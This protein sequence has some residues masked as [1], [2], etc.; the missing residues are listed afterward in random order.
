MSALS[1]FV[2]WWQALAPRERAMLGMMSVAIVAFALW[3]GAVR[4]LQHARDAAMQRHDRA[5]AGLQ[6]VI[7][8]T[9]AIQALQARQPAPPAGD[10]FAR[11]ILDAAAAAHV[12]VARQRGNDTGG[13]EIGIDAV[14]A[15]ALFGWLEALRHRHGIAPALL[16]VTE[17]NGELRVQASFAAPASP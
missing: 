12:P 8:A 9:D 16:D 14:A 17:R 11:T 7:A 2:P 4:P 10:A 15:P 3:L 13:L 6:E 5:A 1:A